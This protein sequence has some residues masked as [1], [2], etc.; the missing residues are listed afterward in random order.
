MVRHPRAGRRGNY[1]MVLLLALLVLLGFVSLVVDLGYQRVVGLQLQHGVEAAAHAGAAYLEQTDAGVTYARETARDV[2][3]LALVDGQPLEVDGV[4]TARG[5]ATSEVGVWDGATFT[6]GGD[7][8]EINA[9]QVVGHNDLDTLIARLA[10]GR[11]HMGVN[12]VATAVAPPPTGAGRV[13]CFLPIAI[14]DCLLTDNGPA[15]LQDLTLRFSP[16]GTDNAGWANPNGPVSASYI[17][18]QLGACDHSGEA[19]VGEPVSLQSGVVASALSELVTA[20]EGSATSWNPDLWGPL[21]SRDP[22][23]GIASARYGNTLEG[24]VF[25]FDGGADY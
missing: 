6:A 9:L 14:P 12:A 13:N 17:R 10:F 21:P 25:L 1:A 16:A 8:A 7:L 11:N 24:V 4:A 23:S 2:G 20:V 22:H 18:D 5:W 19:E 15:G 3:A